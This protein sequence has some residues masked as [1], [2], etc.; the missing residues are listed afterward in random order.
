MGDADGDSILD[1][2]PPSSLSSVVLNVTMPP[3][4]P[5]LGWRIVVDDG[6]LRFRVIPSGS[7]WVQIIVFVL[8]WV[9]PLV[10]AAFSCWLY[11]MSFYKVKVN[12]IGIS[13]ATGLIPLALKRPFQRLATDEDDVNEK[14]GFLAKFRKSSK[15]QQE[16]SFV[17][18]PL[19]KR[20]TVL[21]A[22]MEYDIED[23]GKKVKM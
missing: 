7:M 13:A 16:K 18:D 8:L 14:P 19:Q 21:I 23:W 5:H 10:T 11:L 6:T 15:F 3:P 1:R 4:R 22:T 2:L 12:E 9:V 20:R 17:I